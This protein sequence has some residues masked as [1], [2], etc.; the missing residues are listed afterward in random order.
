[1]GPRARASGRPQL[2]LFFHAQPIGEDPTQEKAFRTAEVDEEKIARRH[3]AAASPL[4]SPR[5]PPGPLSPLTS[6]LDYLR[7]AARRGRGRHRAPRGDAGPRRRRGMRF[8]GALAGLYSR[9]SG[10]EVRRCYRFIL[11]YP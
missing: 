11:V 1:M 4:I 9:P 7:Q 5:S 6:T 2:E 8:V 3:A 10:S